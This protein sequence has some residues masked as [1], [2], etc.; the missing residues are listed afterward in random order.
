MGKRPL[1]DAFWRPSLLPIKQVDPNIM[2][3]TRLDHNNDVTKF[4]M[5]KWTRQR[6]TGELLLR[7]E[8]LKPRQLFPD[9]FEKVVFIPK[10]D[11]L[12]LSMPCRFRTGFTIQPYR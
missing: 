7:N 5:F 6:A 12:F 9:K 4:S 1:Q 8:P 2:V 11:K 10:T 3:Y